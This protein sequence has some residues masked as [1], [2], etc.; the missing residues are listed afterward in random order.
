MRGVLRIIALVA[1]GA[2]VG[3]WLLWKRDAPVAVPVAS[4]EAATVAPPPAASPAAAPAAEP[5]TAKPTVAK[6]SGKV[7]FSRAVGTGESLELQVAGGIALWNPSEHRL[8]V[9]L[10]DEVLSPAQEQQLLGYMRDERLGDSGRQYGVLDLRFRPDATTLD[11][12]GLTS[13]SLTVAAAGGVVRDTADVLSSLQWTGR[14][15]PTPDGG[16]TTPQQ[17]QLT[18]AGSARSADASPAQ[19]NWQLSLAV[20]V[21][22]ASEP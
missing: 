11:R 3:G 13:A 20:P 9:L 15:Q 19:Q 4:A 21:I 6:A 17:L 7:N 22:Q 8:R 16:A 2:A 18:A 14:V 5:V 10:T 12:D 1:L